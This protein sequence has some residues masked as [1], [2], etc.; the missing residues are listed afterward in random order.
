MSEKNRLLKV[1]RL[2]K[3]LLTKAKPA[4]QDIILKLFEGLTEKDPS[5]RIM[6][7]VGAHFGSSFLKFAKSGWTVHCFEPDDD[8][9]EILTRN[10]KKHKFKNVFIDK[11]AV[12]NLETKGTYYESEISSGISSLIRFHPS[13]KEAKEVDITTLSSFCTKNGIST[14][15]FLK[16]T[17]SAI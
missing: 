1:L 15:D 14:I 11:R 3:R 9:R 10:I 7:D 12:S 5:E 13:H 4:E 6:V 2:I 8:N 16:I 17:I